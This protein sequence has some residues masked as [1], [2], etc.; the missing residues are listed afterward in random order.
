LITE[1]IIE[2]L[3]AR[4]VDIDGESGKYDIHHAILTR[5]DVQGLSRKERDKIDSIYNLLVV[6]HWQ[7]IGGDYPTRAEAAEMLIGHYGEGPVYDWFNS[8]KFKVPR[9]LPRVV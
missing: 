4:G 5:G 2:H 8:I 6:D 1:E 9:I 3:H 7:H